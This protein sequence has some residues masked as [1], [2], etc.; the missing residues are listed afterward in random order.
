MKL[1]RGQVGPARGEERG[2]TLI[3]LIIA[4]ALMALIVA[5]ASYSILE[6][7]NINTR[8][9]DHMIAVRQVQDAG[10][11]V[12]HDTYMANQIME[13]SGNQSSPD[14]LLEL[15]WLNINDE[16]SVAA[17]QTSIFTLEN[18]ITQDGITT[19]TLYRTTMAGVKT[20]VAEYLTSA[21]TTYDANSRK[22]MFN[23]QAAVASRG[24][25]ERE[26]RT[27]EIS[28]RPNG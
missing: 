17:N 2:F 26:S 22:L 9:T 23:V 18:P 3:E 16:P 27:Y 20:P 13:T 6:I 8:N 4:V 28:P 12:S 21:N 24:I 7:M 11:W 10:Y 1:K 19:Y 5:A 14:I 25:T 15:Q